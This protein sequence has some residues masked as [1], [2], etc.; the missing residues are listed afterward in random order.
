MISVQKDYFFVSFHSDNEHVH[1][2]ML[3]QLVALSVSQWEPDI[4]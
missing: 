1:L 2:F 3:S 4:S